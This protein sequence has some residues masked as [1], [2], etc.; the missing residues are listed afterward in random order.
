MAFTTYLIRVL[1]LILFKKEI[2]NNFVK[3]FLFYVPYACLACMCFPSILYST[4]SYISSIIGFIFA[5]ILSYKEVNMVSVA[6]LTCLS[7]FVV[8]RIL[9]IFSML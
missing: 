1:P 7:V 6:L 3:S 4:G 5:I 8:E 9:E 2:K